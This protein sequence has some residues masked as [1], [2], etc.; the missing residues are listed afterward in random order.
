[1]NHFKF[2]KGAKVAIKQHLQSKAVGYLETHRVQRLKLEQ[3]NQVQRTRSVLDSDENC[4]LNDQ[5]K[6]S[7]FKDK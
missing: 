7:D 3:H 5:K 2:N 6:W 1:M 4:D